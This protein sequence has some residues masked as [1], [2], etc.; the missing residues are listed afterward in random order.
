MSVKGLSPVD[1]ARS[2]SGFSKT[3]ELYVFSVFAQNPSYSLV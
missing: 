1:S 3:Y 2:K